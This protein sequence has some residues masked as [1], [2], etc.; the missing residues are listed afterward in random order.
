MTKTILVETVMRKSGRPKNNGE[1]PVTAVTA[2]EA[3]ARHVAR[4]ADTKLMV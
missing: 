4:A 1:Q 3:E 2:P